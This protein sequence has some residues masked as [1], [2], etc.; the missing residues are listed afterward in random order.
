MYCSI[1]GVFFLRTNLDSCLLQIPGCTRIFFCVR[2]IWKWNHNFI[3][4]ISYYTKP[5][6]KLGPHG[7][8]TKVDFICLYLLRF[9]FI[10]YIFRN[11]WWKFCHLSYKAAALMKFNGTLRSEQPDAKETFNFITFCNCLFFFF[12]E[13]RSVHNWWL[14]ILLFAYNGSVIASLLFMYISLVIYSPLLIRANTDVRLLYKLP[15]HFCNLGAIEFEATF[16]RV[17]FLKLDVTLITREQDMRNL[18]R[19]ELKRIEKREREGE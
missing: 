16:W 4:L 19:W 7:R 18:V 14:C 5:V 2:F 12:S 9:Y 6:L 3:Y 15:I 10:L 13:H 11:S 1:F 8:W 17:F